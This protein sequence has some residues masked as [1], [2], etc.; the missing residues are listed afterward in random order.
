MITFFFFSTP[1]HLC[2][3]TMEDLA[4]LDSVNLRCQ[5]LD[6]RLGSETFAHLFLTGCEGEQGEI[7]NLLMPTVTLPLIQNIEIL[8]CN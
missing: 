5:D 8:N 3:F 2:S 4:Q 1:L 7:F 6:C